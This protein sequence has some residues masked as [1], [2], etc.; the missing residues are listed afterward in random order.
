MSNETLQE[1]LYG[2]GAHLDPIVCLEDL[3]A[4]LAGEK[5][6][7]LSTFHLADRRAHELLDG[8][9]TEENCGRAA[10]LS[11]TRDRELASEPRSGRPKRPGKRRWRDSTGC[12]AR[13]SQ[14]S[15]SGT[16]VLQRNVA[17]H[18]RCARCA[19]FERA[20]N[21]LAD[22]RTQ[23][24][25]CWPDCLIKAGLWRLAAATRERYLVIPHVTS[26]EIFVHSSRASRSRRSPGAVGVGICRYPCRVA[27]LFAGTACGS[28][29][30]GSFAGARGLR[31]RL[32]IFAVL[33]FVTFP[34]SFSAESSES[35][36]TTWR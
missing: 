10:A 6:R 29:F 16:D 13:L 3:P 28:A 9:R 33:R 15:E 18:P 1:L 30:P 20:D 4:P 8:L 25:P 26:D 35:L 19:A 14:V 17:G 21:T 36:S 12:S 2:K 34:V 5:A 27:C 32:H 7:W 22:G 11:G 31:R 23:Q 24:L